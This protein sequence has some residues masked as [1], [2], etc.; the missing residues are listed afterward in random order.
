VRLRITIENIAGQRLLFLIHQV[1]MNCHD[2]LVFLEDETCTR[3]LER[4]P[5]ARQ[6]EHFPQAMLW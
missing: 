3:L 4:L 2:E 6:T 5:V 1:A